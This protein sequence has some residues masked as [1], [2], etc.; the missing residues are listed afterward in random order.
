MLQ[1]RLDE[2][3]CIRVMRLLLT[4]KRR[5]RTQYSDYLLGVRT[6]PW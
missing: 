1:S 6:P 5:A 3:W 4:E 2:S